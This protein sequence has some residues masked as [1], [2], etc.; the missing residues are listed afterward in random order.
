M[1]TVLH[2]APGFKTGGIE[3]R[4]LDWYRNIDRDQIR[5]VLIKLN[6]I[7]DTENI[8]EFKNL[9][10]VFYNISPLTLKTAFS[11]SNKIKKILI[12]EKVDVVHVHDVNSGV[13]VL[14]VAKML[15][16]SCRILHSRTT[17]NLPHEKNVWIKTLFRKI[18]PLY[19]NHY[20]ACSIEAGIWGIG[21]RYI[22]RIKVIKNGIQI[23]SFI[24]NE[25]IREEIRK[26]LHFEKN[27]IIGTVGR[28]SDQKNIP[29]LL[30]VFRELIKDN[31]NYRLVIVGDGDRNIS[32]DYYDTFPISDY[33]V[34]VGD[35][36]NVWDYYMAFDVFLGTSLYEGFGTTAIEAQATGL[37]TVVSDAFPS[38]V[39]VSEHIQRISLMES[40]TVWAEKIKKQMFRT[41]TKEDAIQVEKK[42]YSANMIAKELEKFY[43]ESI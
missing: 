17:S 28:L 19:A 12:K 34:L 1:I 3:S 10:G 9:G 11:F 29:F 33:I 4:L 41:R 31:L 22:N 36:K 15:G 40:P 23:D 18:A 39:I 32:N 25:D 7:D 14:R 13:F 43:I 42:G 2:Y 5:F 30:D 20:F 6:N 8:R 24:Y 21:K 26:N 37:A 38:T 16:I 35:K 27:T